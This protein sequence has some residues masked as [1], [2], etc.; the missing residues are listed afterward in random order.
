[1]MRECHCVAEI[2]QIYPNLTN[3]FFFLNNALDLGRFTLEE[4]HEFYEFTPLDRGMVA[5]LRSALATLDPSR[6]L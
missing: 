2:A 4:F 1:M 3:H 6:M 5:T